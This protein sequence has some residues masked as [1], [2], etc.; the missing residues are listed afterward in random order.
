MYAKTSLYLRYSSVQGGLV[1]PPPS[2]LCIP[3]CWPI[4]VYP[5]IRHSRALRLRF[6]ASCLIGTAPR[7]ICPRAALDFVPPCET[8]PPSFP[9]SI[10]SGQPFSRP[11]LIDIQYF[12]T[13]PAQPAS[14]PGRYLLW[15]CAARAGGLAASGTAR[16]RKYP[17]G[18]G[19]AGL[20]PLLCNAWG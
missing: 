16:L 8:Q 19:P 20:S 15:R 9:S 4:E 17:P 13:H 5:S 12:R 10:K 1:P 6:G 2:P 18:R 7:F 11:P 14:A 3:V